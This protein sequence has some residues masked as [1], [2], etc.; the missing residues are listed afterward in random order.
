M[1]FYAF[2]YNFKNINNENIKK[3]FFYK[4]LLEVNII[5]VNI[6][7]NTK[8]IMNN[9]INIINNTI[10]IINNTTNINDILKNYHIY[11]KNIK[12][13]ITNTEK[14]NDDYEKIK[15]LELI[16]KKIIEY[17]NN[18]IYPNDFY[19]NIEKINDENNN[20]YTEIINDLKLY[21]EK[22]FND[23]KQNFENSMNYIIHSN[24]NDK[25]KDLKKLFNN[26]INNNLNN[27]NNSSKL[28]NI[29]DNYNSISN[30]CVIYIKSDI[31]H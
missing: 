27:F 13:N 16:I 26:D 10:N 11:N 24:N 25:I 23:R 19:D 1:L 12:N 14:I 18:Y 9:T 5:I 31:K 2:I 20:N 30:A 28:K 22:N 17:I 21:N 6:M 8:N 4:L 7:N 15:E 3:S 29:I